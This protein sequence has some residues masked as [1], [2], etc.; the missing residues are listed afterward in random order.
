[1]TTRCLLCEKNIVDRLNL[2]GEEKDGLDASTF[3]I[4]VQNC[5]K[6]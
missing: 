4:E 1:M 2:Q 3:E 6:I 5:I